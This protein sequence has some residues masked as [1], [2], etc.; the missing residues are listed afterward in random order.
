MLWLDGAGNGGVGDCACAPAAASRAR[1]CGCRHIGDI[2]GKLEGVGQDTAEGALVGG[3]IGTAIPI[4]GIGTGLGATVGSYVGGAYGIVDNF[5][6]D[7]SDAA[8][9]IGHA[10]GGIFGGGPE[11]SEDDYTRMKNACRASGGEP[12]PGIPPDQPTGCI[13]PD[14]TTSGGYDPHHPLQ[15]SGA[16]C[17]GP[18]GISIALPVGFVCG[19]GGFPVPAAF[20]PPPPPRFDAT[21]TAA[22]L[23][24]G[25]LGRAADQIAARVA[26][27]KA[28]AAR[29]AATSSAIRSG[30]L[31]RALDQIRATGKPAAPAPAPKPQSDRAAMPIAPPAGSHALAFTMIGIVAAGAAAAGI[32]EWRRRAH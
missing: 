19:P 2:G 20:A 16:S 24:S 12:N 25:A 1:P 31:A 29:A 7:I 21:K 11:Y 13:Y 26:A 4:P 9:S 23:R 17:S 15:F 27:D 30:G 5:G 22:A 32:Y 18:L 3:A 14:G 6:G 8:S 10:V 28:A